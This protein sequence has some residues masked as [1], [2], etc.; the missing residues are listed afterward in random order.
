MKQRLVLLSAV[1]CFT[2]GSVFGL[3]RYGEVDVQQGTLQVLRGQQ[4]LAFQTGDKAEILK[5]DLLRVG[6]QSRVQFTTV[7]ETSL[8]LG[9]NAIFLVKPWKM[10]SKKGYLQMVFGKASVSQKKITRRSHR[11]QVRTA[12]AV[13]GVRGTQWNQETTAN[14]NTS[15]LTV[16]GQIF[17]LGHQGPEQII[18]PDQFSAVVNGG[19][20][21]KP[22]LAPPAL[23]QETA[24]A[25]NL[26]AAAPTSETAGSLST[27]AQLVESGLVAPVDLEQS[28]QDQVDV[29]EAVAA[30]AAAQ[31]A[32]SEETEG[33]P[34][35]QDEDD[36]D[37]FEQD[38]QDSQEVASLDTQVNLDFATATTS[39]GEESGVETAA[40][41]DTDTYVEPEPPVVDIPGT[42]D[43]EDAIEQNL[44]KAGRLNI[45]VEH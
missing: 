33:E 25:P 32:Q 26:D 36:D 34:S 3:S 28:K 7:E 37:D 4:A 41:A 42:T 31:P 17:L 14:G 19:A 18:F 43:V 44:E 2:A 22:V 6:P 11:F 27:E 39:A 23:R 21:G 24:A 38:F 10:R 29:G 8:T 5:G 1:L 13:M 35:K 45:T 30:P 16:E 15:A 20:A 9:S 40:G 12:M